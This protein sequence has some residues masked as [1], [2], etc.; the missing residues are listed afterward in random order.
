MYLVSILLDCLVLLCTSSC[1]N[2][3]LTPEKKMNGAEFNNF[4]YDRD[5]WWACK[6][7]F[8]G[9]KWLWKCSHVYDG[10]LFKGQFVFLRRSKAILSFSLHWLI[11]LFFSQEKIFNDADWSP[12]LT[13]A[14][15]DFEMT[16][17]P[18]PCP[19]PSVRTRFP[20]MEMVGIWRKMSDKVETS[21]FILGN[22]GNKRE[23]RIHRDVIVNIFSH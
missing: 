3:Y 18:F 7:E 19:S 23:R 14:G 22:R 6:I 5:T 15:S 1:Q 13:L 20:Y 12:F 21:E 4:T 2:P 8:I 9:A 17:G 16:I 11:F 10:A